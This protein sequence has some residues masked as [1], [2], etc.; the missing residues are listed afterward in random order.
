MKR[1]FEMK[2]IDGDGAD[3]TEIIDLEKVYRVR[4][5]PKDPRSGT[6]ELEIYFA[7]GTNT[8]LSQDTADRFLRDY[9]NF[10]A[11]K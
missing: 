9:R 7:D 3:L 2:I 5:R 10:I 6:H 1:Y 8:R 11:Q 4:S